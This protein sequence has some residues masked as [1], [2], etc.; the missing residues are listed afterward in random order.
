MLPQYLQQSFWF[1]FPSI[2]IFC[3]TSTLSMDAMSRLASWLFYPGLT[4]VL[5]STQKKYCRKYAGI[6]FTYGGASTAEK[7]ET[8]QQ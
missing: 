1:A 5:L 6:N 3:D 8:K 7:K 2:N 4:S